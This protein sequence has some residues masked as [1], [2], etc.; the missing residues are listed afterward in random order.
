[1]HKIILADLSSSEYADTIVRLLNAYAKDVMGGG[2]GL[3]DYTKGNLFA[4]LRKRKNCY[5]VLAFVGEAPAGLA[6]CF[7]G[8]STFACK[9]ILNLHDFVVVPEFRG[10]GLARAMLSKVEGMAN[11]LGCCKLTLEVLEGNK[12]AQKIYRRFGFVGYELDPVMG[13]AMFYEKQ[14]KAG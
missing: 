13:R 12:R 4:E 14:L 11:D 6:I 7:E 5:V 9:P 3:S 2:S 8:F 1:M 10:Q